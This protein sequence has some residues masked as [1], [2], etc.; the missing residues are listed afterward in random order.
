VKTAVEH[1]LMVGNDQN[2]FRPQAT[3]T[4]AEVAKALVNV[5]N[6]DMAK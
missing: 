1:G 4:R 2:Q 6:H 5:L 3:A